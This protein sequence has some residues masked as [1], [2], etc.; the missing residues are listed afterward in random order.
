MKKSNIFIISGPS[1]AGE[2]SIMEG[3]KKYFDVERIINTTTRKIREGEAQG[4]PYYFIS[5]QEFQ[6]GIKNN[7]FV[8]Y[9]QE[10]NDNFYGTTKDELERIKKSGKV[11]LWKMEYKGVIKTKKL[12]PDV[13]SIFVNAP[14]MEILE[15]RIRRRSNVSEEY[16]R[17]R[18]EY[19]KEWLKHIDIYD[20]RIINED[21]KLDKTINEIAIIIKKHNG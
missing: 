2:D 7:R 18:M 11:G 9:A 12:Y 13:V 20:Y 6:E 21:G 14:S 8:E 15:E 19:T 3:L 4:K 10:Y 1:G 17:E 5:P 16:I